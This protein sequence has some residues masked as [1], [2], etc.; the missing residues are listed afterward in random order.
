MD[1]MQATNGREAGRSSPPIQL[2]SSNVETFLEISP[3]ALV[4][5]NQAGI[6]VAVNQQAE[7]LFGYPHTQLLDQ[8]LEQLLPKRFLDSHCKH[9]ARYFSA[10]CLRP[11]GAGLSLFGLRQDGTEFPLDISLKPLL[12]DERLIALAA[13]R[14]MSAQRSMEEDLGKRIGE[15]EDA[16]QAAYQLAAI[17]DSSSDAMLSKTLE[18]VI[19]SWNSSAERLYGYRADEVL[20]K[21]LSLI[22]PSD[23][24]E[25]L[26]KLLERIRMGEVI[27]RYETVRERKDGTRVEVSIT[28]SPVRDAR[29]RIVGASTIAHDITEQKRMEGELARHEDKRERIMHKLESFNQQL[30]SL[31]ADAPAGLV[32]F[33][34]RP[35]YQVLLHN[36][37]FQKFFPEPFYSEGTLGKYL[38]EYVP[39]A[40]A[41]GVSEVFRQVV[42]TRQG[43]TLFNF[44]YDGMPRGR[45]WWNWHLAPL[46]K[47]GEVTA[48]TQMVIETTHEVLARQQIETELAERKRAEDALKRSHDELTTG[49]RDLETMNSELKRMNKQQS[50]FIAVVSHEFR[51]ALSGIQGFSELLSE[52]EWS[53]QEVKEYATDIT[54]DA[55]RLT[56]MINEVLDLEQMKAGKTPL[57]VESVDVNVLLRKL[58]ERTQSTASKHHVVYHLD[59][60]LPTIQGDQDQLIQVVSNV[61]SNAVKYSPA[62]GKILLSSQREPHGIR[63]S[64]QDQGIGI[65]EEDL[66][67]IFA[68]YSSIDSEKTRFIQGTGLGLS[69]VRE[70][71]NLHGGTTWV[72]STPGYGSTFHLFLPLIRSVSGASSE[73]GTSSNI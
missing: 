46:I 18:G 60:A 63:V 51:T 27:Q 43:V 5:I 37:F 14:D 52:Q 48:L 33:D 34:A 66:K 71:I 39:R 70:I 35:P 24:Q 32:L 64:I 3:D 25:E 11:M 13:V 72:E 49:R 16:H 73:H 53:P 50:N 26:P 56:H 22:V 58:G 57:H 19:T 69:L 41:D 61:L 20:G 45:T 17:V 42:S 29:G 7:A 55:R 2:S 68:P 1:T 12:L 65:A 21:S 28:V 8:P 36:I 40:E 62:G 9:Q 4:L 67:D 23:R 44:V 10:P 59:E 15:L 47:D 30:Y 54:T 31:F 6:I 38:P